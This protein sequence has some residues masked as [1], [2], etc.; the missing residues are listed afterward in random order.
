MTLEK[1]S[2]RGIVIIGILML[3]LFA[4]SK[5]YASP[6]YGGYNGESEKWMEVFIIDE[7]TIGFSLRVSLGIDPDLNASWVRVGIS[8][9]F[10][11]PYVSN[12]EFSYET[13]DIA[14]L[15][16]SGL[17]PV[18]V[19]ADTNGLEWAIINWVI[20]VIGADTDDN[21]WQEEGLP[22]L[23]LSASGWDS[24]GNKWRWMKLLCVLVGWREEEP[25]SRQGISLSGENSRRL[26][27]EF[28]SLRPQL[29][30]AYGSRLRSLLMEKFTDDAVMEG[31]IDHLETLNARMALPIYEKKG[32]LSPMNPS[33]VR[34]S[35]LDSLL[36]Y[37]E[38]EIFTDEIR[39]EMNVF[40]DS[41]AR[42]IK[43][44]LEAVKEIVTTP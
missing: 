25:V 35:D 6:L 28:I 17:F 5:T 40:S 7:V 9:F 15:S 11:L 42:D 21:W 30:E 2:K 27:K 22:G 13:G 23:Y 41:F 36:E 20:G 37:V 43:P 34:A 1:R 14:S 8:S 10:T 24:K 4:G 12:L 32:S 39:D 3:A 31:V 38:E 16:V 33:S 18:K 26:E 29:T 19:G 44:Q